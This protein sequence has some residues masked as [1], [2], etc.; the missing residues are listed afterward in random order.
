MQNEPTLNESEAQ[1]AI[2]AVRDQLKTEG[3]AAVIA[4][5]DSHGELLALS[6]LDGAKLAPIQIAINKAYTAARERCATADIGRDVRDPLKGFDIAYYGDAR[7]V[8]WGGGIPV[9][10]DGAVLGAV[11]V[12]GLHEQEDM[13]LAAVG[14]AAIHDSLRRD[15]RVKT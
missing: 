13:R 11:G 10:H 8:G 5:V 12:S 4:V 2:R 14:V 15:A 1:V 9:I 3:K 6:R 7:Y